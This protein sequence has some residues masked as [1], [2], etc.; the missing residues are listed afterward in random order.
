MIT[1]CCDAPQLGMLSR[2][3]LLEVQRQLQ[4]VKTMVL[5]NYISK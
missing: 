1:Q 2:E 4:K 5:P 3:K